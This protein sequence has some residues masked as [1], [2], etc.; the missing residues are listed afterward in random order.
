M[1][2]FFYITPCSN[3]LD[4]GEFSEAFSRLCA[5]LPEF[6][7]QTYD[8]L[9]YGLVYEYTPSGTCSYMF[10]EIPKQLKNLVNTIT[11]PAGKYTCYQSQ[12]IRI[13]EAADVFRELFNKNDRFLVV[14]TEL[15]ASKYQ[16]SNPVKELRAIAF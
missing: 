2:S 9:E 8:P 3:P 13:Q 10:I 1:K 6:E 7:Y 11:I 16:I 15:F 5:D 14:E 12:A 4:E